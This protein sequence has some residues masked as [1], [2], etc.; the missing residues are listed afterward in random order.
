MIEAEGMVLL[1]YPAGKEDTH[2]YINSSRDSIEI[3]KIVPYA[4]QGAKNLVSVVIGEDSYMTTIGGVAFWGCTNLEAIVINSE[5]K[6]VGN[7]LFTG[8][9][10]LTIY[11]QRSQSDI[12]D[13]IKFGRKWSAI[14]NHEN[15][16]VVYDYVYEN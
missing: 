4:F 1:Q 9:E 6:N 8:C 10:K 5:V 14:W 16:P 3:D 15:R 13:L 7:H 11:C 12:E 2:F